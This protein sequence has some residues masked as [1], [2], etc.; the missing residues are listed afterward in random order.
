MPPIV[1]VPTEVVAQPMASNV[2]CTDSGDGLT[3]D[4]NL[5]VR[6]SAGVFGLK[7]EVPF[8]GEVHA[9]VTGPL[10]TPPYEGETTIEGTVAAGKVSNSDKFCPG[11]LPGRLNR[12]AGLPDAGYQV[13]WPTK[14]SIYH[15]DID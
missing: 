9:T 7:C 10:L 11:Q 3:M 14:V 2:S 4:L 15:P 1:D 8:T 5:K 13:H 12:I 6:G